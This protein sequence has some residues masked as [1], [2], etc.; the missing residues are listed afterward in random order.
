[1]GKIT[2]YHPV[3][4]HVVRGAA[5]YC[6]FKFAT[7]KWMRSTP[8]GSSATYRFVLEKTPP[9]LKDAPI[10]LIRSRLLE[11]FN[12]DIRVGTMR[13]TTKGNITGELT[14]YLFADAVQAQIEGIGA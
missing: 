9:N 5:E 12:A 14:T 7:L 2:H 8:T 11:C 10:G 3:S 1:M 6:G 13:Q 4:L